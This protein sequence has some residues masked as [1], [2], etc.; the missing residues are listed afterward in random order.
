VEAGGAHLTGESDLPPRAGLGSSAA[1]ATAVARCL[2]SFHGIELDRERLFAA[3]QSAERVFHGNPSGLDATVAIGGGVLRF[4]RANGPDPLDVAA[5][6]L[7]LAH[8]GAEGRTR[9]TVAEFARTLENRPDEGRQRLARICEL[10]EQGIAAL[11][12][13]DLRVLG[14]A[15]DESQ[16]QLAWFGVSTADL[17][18]IC[19]IARSAGALGA[20]L[21]GGGGGGCAVALVRADDRRPVV[22]AVEAAGYEVLWP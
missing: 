1:L 13:G 10:V 22:R 2:A 4:D 17:D 18:R 5:P 12:R 19:D 21:T 3:V 7:V 9:E 16:E 14:R 20:K 11:E 6:E 8:S 15:M